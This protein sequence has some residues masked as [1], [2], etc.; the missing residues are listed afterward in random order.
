MAETKPLKIMTTP[1]KELNKSEQATIKKIHDWDFSFLTGDQ[2]I[3]RGVQLRTVHDEAVEELK[4]FFAV[5][6]L[7]DIHPMGCF[8]PIVAA[9][10]HSFILDTQRYEDFCKKVYGKTIH[11]IPSNYGK[12]VMDNTLWMSV[13]KEWFGP[14]PRVWK[15][16]LDG[17]EIP[18]YEHA[19][20]VQGN[21]MSSDMDSDDG[22]YP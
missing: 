20:N 12:G 3:R 6:V 18:G 2:L 8:G 7:R 16:D 21:V 9:A 5:K 10:W 22:A 17:K 14:F 4:K 1:W 13:Y 15:L 19:M 11:H